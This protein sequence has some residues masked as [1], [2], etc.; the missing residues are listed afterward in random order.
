MIEVV[1]KH[2]NLPSLR[3]D[4]PRD[5]VMLW[6]ALNLNMDGRMS[7]SV[8]RPGEGAPPAPGGGNGFARAI[9]ALIA[10][11]DA[12]RA[13]YERKLKFDDSNKLAIAPPSK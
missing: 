6:T 13:K 9:H 7:T 2:N 3:G 4:L 12:L 11:K 10:L 5:S 1:K 8:R